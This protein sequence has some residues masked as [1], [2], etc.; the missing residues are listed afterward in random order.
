MT[1]LSVAAVFELKAMMESH[2][3]HQQRKYCEQ[4]LLEENKQFQWFGLQ[5]WHPHLLLMEQPWSLLVRK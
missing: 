1:S 3:E 2:L 5:V 4:K